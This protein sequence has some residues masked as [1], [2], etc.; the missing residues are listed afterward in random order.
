MKDKSYFDGPNVKVEW[1]PRIPI[2]SHVDQIIAAQQFEVAEDV[3]PDPAVMDALEEMA[4]E[5]KPK[6]NTNSRRLTLRR[7]GDIGMIE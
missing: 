5:E 7:Y 1:I 2:H 4:Q 6:R 3:L